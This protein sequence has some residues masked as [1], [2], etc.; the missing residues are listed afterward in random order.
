MIFF[1]AFLIALREIRR[2]LTRA[3]LTVLGIIIGIAA[4]ITSVTIGQGTT[5]AVKEQFTNLGANSLYLSPSITF[6]PRIPGMP[7]P[8]NFSEDDV[9]AIRSQI[10]GVTNAIPMR[11]A[12]Q[13]V[14]FQ[15][16]SRNSE[17]LGT[18]LDY[19][20]MNRWVINRGRLFTQ[21]EQDKGA[22][23]CVVGST[24]IRELFEG[25]NVEPLGAR[26]RI[27]NVSCEIIGIL[28]SK[29][30]MGMRDQDATIILPLLTLQRRIVGRTTVQDITLIGIATQD[31]VSTDTI[32]AELSK[33]M[34]QRR[35]L[36]STQ[37]NN[38]SIMDPRQFAA[39]RSNTIQIMTTLLA[40][41]AGVSLLV[42]GIGIMNIMLVSVTER[43]REIGIRMAIGARAKEVLL[44]FLIEATTLACVGGLAGIL[45]AILLCI[46]L[47]K[48]IGVGF[49]F[50]PQIN[51]IA[52]VFSALI[53][54]IFG[55]MPARR[56]AAL[57][58]IEALRHE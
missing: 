25:T 4:V 9:T 43:T 28:E 7:S 16:N 38:F 33:L 26:I 6:G 44:Q 39:A 37:D 41:V 52:V 24:I 45:L 11:S 40:I 58:P 27:K 18:T 3:F 19:F 57:D 10:P 5:E 56:A 32:N 20:P 48:A 47:S 54:I 21:N 31:G 14:V 51:I 49:V 50:G 22:A 23:V 46:L 2:N 30:Q 1:N 12:G 17:V 36:A 13:S 34:R 15:Q 29:G 8:P 42:G 35:R 53:G 55:Y